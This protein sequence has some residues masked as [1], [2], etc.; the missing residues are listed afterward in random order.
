MRCSHEEQLFHDIDQFRAHMWRL[1]IEPL[2][3]S[4][5]RLELGFSTLAFEDLAITRLDCNRKV[6]DRLHMDPSWL[7][8][9]V[10]LAPQRWGAHE[11]PLKALL[12]SHPTPSTATA[13]LT[14]SAAWKQPSDS[15][16]PMSLASAA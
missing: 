15:I 6:S 1:E 13:C 9:V 10:Q 3:L 11:A 16:L 7:L 5:G 2:Q 4:R 12:S 14:V 8:L